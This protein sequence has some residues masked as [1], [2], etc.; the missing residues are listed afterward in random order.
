MEYRTFD[1]TLVVRLDPGE[2]MVMLVFQVPEAHKEEFFNYILTDTATNEVVEADEMDVDP[3]DMTGVIG[4]DMS[5]F[6][7][8]GSYQIRVTGKTEEGTE[9]EASGPAD[10]EASELSDETITANAQET[11]EHPFME[12]T[13]D[14]AAIIQDSLD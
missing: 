7:K 9:N 4:F 1:E 11:D 8:G 14:E 10:R 13:P 6:E 2:E 3:E 5:T 12:A